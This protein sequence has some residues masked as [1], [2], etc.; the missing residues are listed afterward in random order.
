MTADRVAIVAAARTA[1]GKFGG[2]L[3]DLDPG[4][5]GAVVLEQVVKRA[6]VQPEEV[7]EVIMGNVLAGGHGMNVARQSAL[8]AGYPVT[9]PAYIVNKVCGSGLKSAIMG[10]QAI[11]LGDDDIVVAG[12]VESMSTALYALKNARWGLRMGTGEAV[13]IMVNDGLWDIFNNIHMG[14]TAEVLAE[15]YKIS[16]QEQD[17]FAVRSQNKAEA[18]IK[19]GRFKDEIVPVTV[20]QHKG[21]PVLFDTD[22][23]P[24]FGTTAETLSKLKPAFKKD[25]TVTAGNSSGINDGASAVVLMSEQKVKDRAIEPLGWIVSYGYC[26]VPPEIMGIGPVCATKAALKKAGIGMGR[27]DLVEENEAFAAQSIAVDRDLGWNRDIVNVNGGAIALGHPIGCSGNR[28][29]VSLL[30]EMKRRNVERGLATLC[31]GGGMGIAM[32]VQR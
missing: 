22:E 16:R 1:V 3:K 8:W 14:G 19:A 15:R 23:F 32:V 13:D 4:H 30:Y 9:V 21:P 17:E 12:G 6:S 7:D 27:I 28:I 24:R 20:H 25:G 10:A 5:L 2:A 18:A 29:L 26:A 11:M 31:I